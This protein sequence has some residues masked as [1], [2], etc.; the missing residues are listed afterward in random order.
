MRIPSNVYHQA[1][2]LVPRREQTQ[3]LV[4][5]EASEAP[6]S[7]RPEDVTL[8]VSKTARR[9]ATEQAIDIDRIEQLRAAIGAGKLEIDA[10]AMADVVVET[11]G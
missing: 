6:S 11:G 5:P 4:Q 3:S 8:A 7:S 9:M 2:K 10:Q 1:A